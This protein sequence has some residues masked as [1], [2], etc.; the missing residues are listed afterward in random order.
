MEHQ[1]AQSWPCPR[2]A[3]LMCGGETKANG[4]I[5]AQKQKLVR[6]LCIR[7]AGTPPPSAPGSSSSLERH[8]SVFQARGWGEPRQGKHG[9]A[10]GGNG[11]LMG[12]WCCAVAGSFPGWLGRE[13][14]PRPQDAAF[15]PR[16]TQWRRVQCG[17][18]IS[19]ARIH[20]LHFAV[21]LATGNIRSSS[22][23]LC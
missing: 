7:R 9:R 19:L 23:P 18:G 8:H 13:N 22:L 20:Q 21:L 11:K 12:P 14:Y 2:D 6:E 17:L 3:Y 16:R 1:A 10:R 15:D 5:K 4:K